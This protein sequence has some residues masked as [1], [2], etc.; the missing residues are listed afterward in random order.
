ME[1]N[2]LTHHGIKG[3]RWGVRRFQTKSGSLTAAGKKRYGKDDDPKTKKAEDKSKGNASTDTHDDYKKVRAKTVRQMSDTELKD[4]VNRLAMEK[5]YNE[6]NPPKVSMG[7]QF[8]NKFVLP[9]AK[10][11]AEKALK[12]YIDSTIDTAFKKPDDKAKTDN[13]SDTKTD[14]KSNDTSN[15]NNNSKSGAHGVKG[16]KWEKRSADKDNTV[17]DGE[18]SGEGTSRRSNKDTRSSSSDRS[19]QTIYDVEWEDV[20]D[21]RTVSDTAQVF[22]GLFS[23]MS[24]YTPQVSAGQTFVAGLLEAP[25]N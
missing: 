24:S 6:L 10:Y 8:I 9:N 5:R 19:R 3:Q 18:V 2:T 15:A 1:Q 7:K 21:S 12:K 25:K 20:T 22:S 11:A 13:K 4:A 16:A 17:Y 23:K 14:N